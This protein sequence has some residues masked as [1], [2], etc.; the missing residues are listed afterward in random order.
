MGR[1]NKTKI[2]GKGAF[3]KRTRKQ[4]GLSNE[5]IRS[6]WSAKQAAKKA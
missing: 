6:L 3:Y 2:P 4:F 5:A 1:K